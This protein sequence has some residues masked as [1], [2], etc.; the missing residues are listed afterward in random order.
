MFTTVAILAIISAALYIGF[1]AAGLVL[2]RFNSV[3]LTLFAGQITTFAAGAGL[4][5]MAGAVGIV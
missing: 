5:F 3:A 2:A 1:K 4:L